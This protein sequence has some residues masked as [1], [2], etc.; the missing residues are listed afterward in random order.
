MKTNKSCRS[1]DQQLLE[2]VAI[3]VGETGHQEAMMYP[4]LSP[5]LRAR[6]TIIVNS[7]D[8]FARFPA[9][10]SDLIER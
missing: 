1:V 4:F 5:V 10:C 8:H 2:E 3:F 6:T 9:L 7:V